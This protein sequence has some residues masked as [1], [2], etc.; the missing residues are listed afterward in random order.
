MLLKEKRE[1][2]SG[3][4]ETTEKETGKIKERIPS[5]MPLNVKRRGSEAEIKE[6]IEKTKKI[7]VKAERYEENAL[8]L[9]PL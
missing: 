3:R 7:D 2:K 4:M 9:P 5:L 6:R 1:Q 8:L